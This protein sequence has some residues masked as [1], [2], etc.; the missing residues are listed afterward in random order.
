[1]LVLKTL[2]DTINSSISIHD[3]E[4]HCNCRLKETVSRPQVGLTN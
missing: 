4:I 2:F 1:M 3:K